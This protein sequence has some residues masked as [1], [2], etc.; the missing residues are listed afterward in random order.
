[1]ART[2]KRQQT[3]LDDLDA[4]FHK[5]KQQISTALSLEAQAGTQGIE[6]RAV[7]RRVTRALHD[8]R[9]DLFVWIDEHGSRENARIQPEEADEL[10]QMFADAG[11]AE[12]V[13]ELRQVLSESAD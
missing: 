12:D 5:A 6:R 7:V 3:E 2:A 1:M 13:G 11:E 10:R 4:V 9:V 8:L